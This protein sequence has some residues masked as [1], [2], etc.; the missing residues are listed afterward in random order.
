[1]PF[2]TS[3]SYQDASGWLREKG[4]ETSKGSV[5]RCV[6]RSNAA[7]QCLPKIQSRTEALV[8]VVRK[9]PDTNYT[10]AGLM[11]MAGSLISRLAIAEDK[12]DYLLLDKVGRL[13]ASLSRTKVYGDKVRQDVKGKADLAFREME[14]EIM[15]TIKSDPELK[16]RLKEILTHARELMLHD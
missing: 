3:S 5:G 15:R 8:D 10:E 4:Y 11:L 2:N 13:T 16:A 1:M 14:E 7:T 9:N 12:F 6:T